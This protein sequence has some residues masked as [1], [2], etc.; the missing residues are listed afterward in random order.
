MSSR[1]TLAALA[2]ALSGFAL[3]VLAADADPIIVKIDGQPILRSEVMKD[4]E[5]L[6]PQAA[7]MP[8]QM[9]L[10]RVLDHMVATRVGAGTI[11]PSGG[12]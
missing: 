6:G 10:P 9:L 5:R 2:F 12:A 4:I 7:Q 1:L 8:Q 11:S 3:P